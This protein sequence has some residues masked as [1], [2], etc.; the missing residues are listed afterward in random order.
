MNS[1]VEENDVSLAP[2]SQ[3]YG[4]AL[5]QRVQFISELVARVYTLYTLSR[6]TYIVEGQYIHCRG[7]QPPNLVLA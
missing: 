4:S 6:A 7:L 2:S 3:G 5:R 1:L